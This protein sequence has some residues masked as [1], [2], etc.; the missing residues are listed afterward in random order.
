ML[1][2]F[3]LTYFLSCLIKFRQQSHNRNYKTYIFI[4]KEIF[5]RQNNQQQQ[6]EPL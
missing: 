4:L 3:I 6:H 5:M 2:V 1:F